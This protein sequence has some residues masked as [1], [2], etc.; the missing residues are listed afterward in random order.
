MLLTLLLLLLKRPARGEP[1]ERDSQSRC[2]KGIRQGN[3]ASLARSEPT[4]EAGPQP[5]KGRSKINCQYS[6]LS[7]ALMTP[8]LTVAYAARRRDHRTA[9][10]QASKG[11]R[12]TE[13]CCRNLAFSGTPPPLLQQLMR[14]D[15]IER[16][17]GAPRHCL[18]RL[19]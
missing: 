14:H 11:S 5:K 12:R 10:P 18:Q 13:D 15:C 19:G 2:G 1:P 6:S 4:A 17:T 7:P 16:S 8:L 3:A 9:G